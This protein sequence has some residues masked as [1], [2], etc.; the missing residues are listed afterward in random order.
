MMCELVSGKLK[1]HLFFAISLVL[2]FLEATMV[3][4]PAIFVLIFWY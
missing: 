4:T 1:W 3:S 2:L